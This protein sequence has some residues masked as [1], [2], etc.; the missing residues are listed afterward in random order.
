MDNNSYEVVPYR[1]PVVRQDVVVINGI[2]YQRVHEITPTRRSLPWRHNPWLM[3]AGAILAMALVGTLVVCI[4]IALAAVVRAVA[5]HA[6]EV[7]LT[8]VAL[9]GAAVMLLS[10]LTKFRQS[11]R[12]Y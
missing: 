4:G 11:G 9:F 3:V 8:L 6:L 10:S 5:A 1:T 7:G 2:Q 12:R